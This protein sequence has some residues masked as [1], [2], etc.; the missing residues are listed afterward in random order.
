MKLRKV[1]VAVFLILLQLLVGEVSI[2]HSHED[3]KLHLDCQLCLLQANPQKKE[4]FRAAPK[5]LTLFVVYIQDQ[6][7]GVLR[8]LEPFHITYY[9]R[10]PPG[11]G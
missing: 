1:L 6:K 2:L 8:P 5:S 7:P 11:Q 3:H 10:A 4:D 9:L